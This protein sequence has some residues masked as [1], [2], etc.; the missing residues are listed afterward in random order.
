MNLTNAFLPGR[1]SD[2]DSFLIALGLIAL[3]DGVRLSVMGASASF[4]GF[5]II[6]V[7]SAAVFINRF[8]ATGRQGPLIILPLGVALAAKTL[9]AA[10]GILG[11]LFPL[12]IAYAEEEGVDLND[13][14]AVQQT[15]TP[16][17]QEGF[18][19]Y[20]EARPEALLEAVSAGD[21]PSL[22]AWWGVLLLFGFWAAKPK[23]I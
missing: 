2:P 6:I 9:A 22:V 21:W 7:L 19:A 16:E 15:Q 5:G 20:A 23:R 12:V 8:R 14:Q 1:S 4:F 11:G 10:I 3:A 17:F 18:R 13:P